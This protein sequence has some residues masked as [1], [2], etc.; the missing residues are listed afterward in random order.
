LPDID[1][2][3]AQ[4]YQ[5]QGVLVFGV[6]PSDPEALVAD[7]VEQTGVSFPVVR[8]QSTRG[9][10]AYP[11]G[12][13]FPYPRDVVIGKDGVVRSIKNSFNAQEMQALVEDLLAQ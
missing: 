5:G 8:D 7:F 6:H 4:P 13:N 11:P 12:T 2:A 1:A 10:F 9:R 3:I